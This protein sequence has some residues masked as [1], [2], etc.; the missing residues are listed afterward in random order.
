MPNDHAR[1]VNLHQS[2]HSASSFCEILATAQLTGNSMLH[3]ML[4]V[5]S[6]Q[7]DNNESTLQCS[8]CADGVSFEIPCKDKACFGENCGQSKCQEETVLLPTDVELN[9][10]VRAINAKNWCMMKLAPEIMKP[11]LGTGPWNQEYSIVKMS[12]SWCCTVKSST[13]IKVVQKSRLYR[14]WHW[15]CVR[16]SM[17]HPETWLVKRMNWPAWVCM[18][19]R[20]SWPH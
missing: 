1:Q 7:S 17:Q 15:W 19:P 6:F 20:E 14:G 12:T 13:K 8:C 4:K 2:P 5:H 16:A 18:K 9:W 3:V 10:S 11:S